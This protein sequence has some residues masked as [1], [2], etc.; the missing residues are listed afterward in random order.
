MSRSTLRCVGHAIASA[1]VIALVSSLVT[2]C[3]LSQV[4]DGTPLDSESI[5]SIAPGSST[6]K[7][8]VRLLGPPDEVVHSNREHDPLFEKVYIYKRPTTRT[9]G[10]FLLLFST[11]RS[12]T[13]HDRVAVFF[14]EAGVVE[15]VASRLEGEIAEYGMPW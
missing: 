13:K 11:H 8:V 2:G 4:T 15:H 12:D 3:V 6:R 9:T 5:A 7:D 1:L 10:M 14:D